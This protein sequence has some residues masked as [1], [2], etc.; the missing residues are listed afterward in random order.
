MINLLFS[1]DRSTPLKVLCLGAHCDDIEIGCGGTILRLREWYPK[2]E[3][4]WLV[5]SSNEERR[6]ETFAS[7]TRFGLVESDK[8]VHIEAFRD[9][10]LPYEGA[11]VKQAIHDHRSEFEPDVV[12]TH[13]RND[14]HQ[15]HR[16]VSDVTWNAYRDH[17]I[18][19]YE[20]PKWDGDLGTPNFFVPLDAAHVESKLS[21]LQQ[22]YCS[23]QMKESFRLEAFRGLMALRG[24]E[25]KS[26]GGYAEAF[27]SRKLVVG[28]TES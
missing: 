27:Y 20:I 7:A 2:L 5:L 24:V 18:L 1:N 19:E 8:S 15:D 17:L 21:I 10:Y 4:R 25:A 3:I 28:P 6:A 11:E 14:R 13:Y 26:T 16:M 23:Q 22:E 9:G 12:F